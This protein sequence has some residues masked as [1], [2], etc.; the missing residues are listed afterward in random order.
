MNYLA[1]RPCELSKWTANSLPQTDLA[2]TTTFINQTLSAKI[3]KNYCSEHQFPK[4][5]Y[6]TQYNMVKTTK[7]RETYLWWRKTKCEQEPS[8]EKNRAQR[9]TFDGEQQSWLGCRDK[10]FK[11]AWLGCDVTYL[12]WRR[13]IA[14][15]KKLQWR[16][17]L[18]EQNRA[19]NLIF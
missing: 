8:M 16:R 17:I 10:H 14:K 4:I 18:R 3:L 5:T 1:V 13:T 2:V 19:R 12:R 15:K 9:T 6:G 11:I 7:S